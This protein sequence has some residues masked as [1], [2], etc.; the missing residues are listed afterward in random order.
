MEAV[1]EALRQ[2]ERDELASH[3]ARQA[4][5]DMKED[6]RKMTRER[7]GSIGGD[8]GNILH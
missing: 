4:T 7:I 1:A 3:A 8:T 6:A 2:A 5:R